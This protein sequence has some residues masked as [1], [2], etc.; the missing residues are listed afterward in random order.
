MLQV[1]DKARLVRLHIGGWIK[2]NC[3]DLK[4]WVQCA[5]Q[6]LYDTSNASLKASKRRHMAKR[7][8]SI[9]GVH[10][11]LTA[12]QENTT[13]THSAEAIPLALREKGLKLFP[14]MLK[15][16]EKL[17]EGARKLA[18]ITLRRAN[19][20]DPEM[21]HDITEAALASALESFRTV[22]VEGRTVLFSHHLRR[23]LFGAKIDYLKASYRNLPA[24][25]SIDSSEQEES[26]WAG[27]IPERSSQSEG[28]ST[29]NA[30]IRR[31][32]S[33]FNKLQRQGYATA[34]EIRIYK[35]AS[36]FNNG[37]KMSQT[38]IAATLK[39]SDGQPPT[40][41]YVSQV[42]TKVDLMLR[43]LAQGGR[44]ERFMATVFIDGPHEAV[45]QLN[46]GDLEVVRRLNLSDVQRD[47]L[48]KLST[49]DTV[50]G[51][52]AQHQKTYTTCLRSIAT[53]YLAHLVDE[54]K[55]KKRAPRN[56][57]LTSQDI[58]NWQ[59]NTDFK[60]TLS[61]QQRNILAKTAIQTR[62]H[63]DS[64]FSQIIEASATEL[65]KNSKALRADL[66]LIRKMHQKYTLSNSVQT[67]EMNK[68]EHR[69]SPVTSR[70]TPV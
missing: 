38:E 61:P 58:L 37:P 33:L 60:K 15:A 17:K 46:R 11:F 5:R 13:T 10:A 8:L 56:E 70:M 45:K 32:E 65:G 47:A 52:V 29:K 68:K 35:L 34:E 41:Q 2:R 4:N 26:P 24:K 28:S 31:L 63:T 16:M 59:N 19:I 55:S 67:T 6:P 14:E 20:K 39:K 27:N 18:C 1:L 22:K 3:P 50:R 40:H 44:A 42:I 53:K 43:A 21:N 36:R 51:T 66:Y 69:T 48:D 12:L 7:K 49:S 30:A 54:P 9:E 57:T 23:H 64:N 62:R 25:I